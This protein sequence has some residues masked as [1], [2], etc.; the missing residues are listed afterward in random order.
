MSFLVALV[1]KKMMGGTT[2]YTEPPLPHLNLH[3]GCKPQRAPRTRFWH[4]FDR[5]LTLIGWHCF[6]SGTD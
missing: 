5:S 4:S 3:L 1:H 2:I 6:D